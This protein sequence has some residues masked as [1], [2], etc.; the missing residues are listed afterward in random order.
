MVYMLV[1]TELTL[2]RG[3]LLVYLSM[4]GLTAG[5]QTE[6]GGLSRHDE[7]RAP[8]VTNAHGLLSPCTPRSRA[9]GNL[10]G[11][12]EGARIKVSGKTAPPDPGSAGSNR[13]SHFDE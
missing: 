4:P 3:P 13:H 2:L 12:A 11:H 8:E 7:L 6:K 10:H 1:L 9:K 5:A